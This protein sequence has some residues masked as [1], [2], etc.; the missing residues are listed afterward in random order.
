MW[1]PLVSD[2]G[3]AW[4]GVGD[5]VQPVVKPDTRWPVRLRTVGDMTTDTAAPAANP[6]PQGMTAEAQAESAAR[7]AQMPDVRPQLQAALDLAVATA[8][9][10]GPDQLDRPTP[11]TEFDV[12]GLIRHLA[13]ASDRAVLAATSIGPVPDLD[14]DAGVAPAAV[15]DALA[16]TAADFGAAWSNDAALD[17]I[18]EL[19]WATLPARVL[20][21]IYLSEISTHTWDLARATGQ[22]PVYDEGAVEIALATMRMG[23]PADGREQ[24]PF[25]PVQPVA[26]DAP[27]IERLVAWC[28]R[29]PAWSAA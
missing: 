7:A 10:V 28:G 6:S 19:P 17:R 23:L 22:Q 5:R 25:G 18:V 27:A 12:D 13:G 15:V 8:R 9:N 11:C 4:H 1:N 14:D 20:L 24:S 26:D 21:A 2:C 29:P 3:R 16:A